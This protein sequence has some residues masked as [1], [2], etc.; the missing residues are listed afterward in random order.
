MAMLEN[1][2]NLYP[3]I[4]LREKHGHDFADYAHARK[5]HDVDGWVR[6]EPEQVL[7]QDRI[8]AIV[9]VEDAG[10]QDALQAQQHQSDGHYRR[11]QHL[12]DAVA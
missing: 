11:A 12:D 7:E 4:A 5:N 9:G 1:A 10:M 2:T 6:I 3:K 8:A